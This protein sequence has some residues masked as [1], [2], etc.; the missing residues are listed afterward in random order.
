MSEFVCDCESEMLSVCR[1]LPFYGQLSG[2]SYC[3]LHLPGDVVGEARREALTRK[4]DAGDY[5]FRGVWFSGD[6]DWFRPTSQF[7]NFCFESRPNFS[8]AVFNVK[9]NFNRAAFNEGAVF[10]NTTFNQGA[11][12][13]G[14]SFGGTANFRR[15]RFKDWTEFSSA[16]FKAT[17]DFRF[18]AFTRRT[19]F[20]DVTFGDYVLFA[21]IYRNELSDWRSLRL[22]IR[23]SKK[24]KRIHRDVR[25]VR[26]A[27]E[28]S[29]S[30]ILLCFFFALRAAYDWLYVWFGE[31]DE[32]MDF[33]FAKIDSP[34][35]V[36]FDALKLRPHWFV[37]IECRKFNF[38]NIE[39]TGAVREGIHSLKELGVMQ[40][41]RLLTTTFQQLALNSE[42]NNRYEEAS[43]FRYLSMEAERLRTWRG[44]NPWRL[45]WWYWLASGYGERA[46]RAF[47]ILIGL[48]LLF[49]WLYTDLNLK[50]REPQ[51][52]SSDPVFVGN[53]TSIKQPGTEET[54]RPLRALT[55]SLGVMTLQKPEPRPVTTKAQMLVTVESILGPLQA[56]LFALAVRR[57]FMR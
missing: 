42:E 48:W 30:I 17:A 16:E 34:E 12:F 36:Y 50:W 41:H 23:E 3:A 24:A 37:N 22:I 52:G 15:T 40:P 4:I 7:S 44:F 9:A 5:D 29:L 11:N 49:G 21:G 47:I 56:A 31:Q 19:D 6:F 28:Y 39:W 25:L 51:T 26:L 35:R 8:Y 55:Y 13:Y 45:S 33:Q 2:K 20:T 57:K 10:E 14:A 38:T 46:L 32:R 18:A 27:L 54:Q 53:T 1:G 43:K